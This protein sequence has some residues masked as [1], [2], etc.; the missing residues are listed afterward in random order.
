[1]SKSQAA[2]RRRNVLMSLMV[3]SALSLLIGLLPGVGFMLVIFAL[4]ATALAGFVT[5]SARQARLANDRARQLQYATRSMAQRPAMVRPRQLQ[6]Y[7][8]Q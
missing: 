6:R 8:Y 4:S 1:M 7:E 3:V 2:K 5:V